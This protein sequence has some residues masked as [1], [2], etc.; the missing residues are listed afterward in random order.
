MNYDE[1]RVH[2][3]SILE[4][5]SE[6]EVVSEQMVTSKFRKLCRKYHPDRGKNEEEKNTLTEK[7]KEIEQ[8]KTWMTGFGFEKEKWEMEN[9]KFAP[10]DFDDEDILAHLFGMFANSRH[11]REDGHFEMPFRMYKNKKQKLSKKEKKERRKKRREDQERLDH[12]KKTDPE[13]IALV[14]KI[15]KLYER[16]KKLKGQKRKK[17]RDAVD[18]EI[19]ELENALERMALSEDEEKENELSEQEEEYHP[20]NQYFQRGGRGHSN[21][22]Q[23]QQ[24]QRRK[25]RL[26]KEFFTRK[27]R[28]RSSNHTSFGDEDEEY[29]GSHFHHQFHHGQKHNYRKYQRDGSQE[30]CIIC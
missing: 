23:R 27:K 3:C 26:P 29:S 22:S 5:S 9:M 1:L 14:E 19:D 18:K 6:E 16:R 2:H 8:S 10:S 30:E 4:F 24:K 21:N 20:H 13:A 11:F 15:D 28:P 25:Q 12:I 17:K 7:F